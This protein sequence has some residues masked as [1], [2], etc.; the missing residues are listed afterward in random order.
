MVGHRVE[1]DALPVERERLS[2]GSRSP[3]VE[4]F[5][6]F[7]PARISRWL[8]NGMGTAEEPRN[9]GVTLLE[10]LLTNGGW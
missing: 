8:L 6:I 7:F 10:G 4:V 5:Q 3:S 1:L 2:P 9:E